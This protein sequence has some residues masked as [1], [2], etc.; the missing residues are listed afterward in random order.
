MDAEA[1][2]VTFCAAPDADAAF[3]DLTIP[4][5][6]SAILASE[7]ALGQATH[8][9]IRD[10][11]ARVIE[12]QRTETV[13]LE[14]IRIEISAGA[15]PDAGT[16]VADGHPHDLGGA[17]QVIR[18]LTPDEVACIDRETGRGTPGPPRPTAFPAPRTLSSSA[19][20]SG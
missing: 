7:A 3:I 12:A 4:H 18:A 10:I 1:L 19:R 5:H 14:T 8:P 17:G 2:V 11:A 6:E 16:P 9:E 13:T 15:T 20:N